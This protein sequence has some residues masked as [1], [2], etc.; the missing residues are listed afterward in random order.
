MSSVVRTYGNFHLNKRVAC[1]C[2]GASVEVSCTSNVV[3]DAP[4]NAT[5]NSNGVY[6]V[7]LFPRSNGTVAALVSNCRLFV[8]T[9]LSNC[10]PNLPSSTLVSNLEF[11]KTVTLG[12]FRVTYMIASAFTLQ[13]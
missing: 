11:V 10:N 2:A 13:S 7:M 5:T 3:I 8:L 9:P 6:S 12:F 4:M 1:A